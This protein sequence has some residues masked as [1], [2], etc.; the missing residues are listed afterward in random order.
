MFDEYERAIGELKSVVVSISEEEFTRVLDDATD[1]KDCSSIQSILHHVVRAGYGYAT[2][3]REAL[4]M[5]GTRPELSPPT[6][7]DIE[8]Q[9]DEMM[10]YSEDTLEGKWMLSDDEIMRVKIDAPW[11]QTYDMEQLLEHA[12]VHVLRHRR[13]IER[14][15]SV[16]V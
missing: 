8:T 12:I 13:Q 7:E 11:G 14:L 2:D 15:R 3:I 6:P 5:P 16:H 10:S 1:D 4:D 9:I